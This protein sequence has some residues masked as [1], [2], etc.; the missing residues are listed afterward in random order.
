MSAFEEYMPV[1]LK[2]ATEPS[3][4]CLLTIAGQNF[5]FL[6]AQDLKDFHAKIGELITNEGL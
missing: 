4:I 6:T 3:E 1:T 5:Q 2:K